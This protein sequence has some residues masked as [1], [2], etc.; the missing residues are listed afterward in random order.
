MQ[1]QPVASPR[2]N[3][4]MTVREKVDSAFPMILIVP[5]V[6]LL[7]LINSV[8]SLFR[9]VLIHDLSSWAPYFKKYQFLKKIV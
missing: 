7:I 2:Q 9:Y 3:W 6:I 4:G 8:K 1:P 5:E